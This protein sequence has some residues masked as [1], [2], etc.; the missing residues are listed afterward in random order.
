[1]KKILGIDYGTQR[2]G[3]AVNYNVLVEPLEV[4]ESPTMS[5]VIE[6]VLQLIT[7]HAVELIVVGISESEMAKKTELFITSLQKETTIPIVQHDET[8]SS[9][10]VQHKLLESNR[11]QAGPIDHYAAAVILDDWID[12]H[13][14]F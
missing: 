4:I 8:L 6:R 13:P 7:E 11:K 10:D 3:V 9:Q 2:V 14:Q 12:T 1:M 5:V